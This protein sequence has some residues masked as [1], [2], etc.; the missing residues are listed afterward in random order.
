MSQGVSSGAMAGRTFSSL[1]QGPGHALERSWTSDQ[2]T[3]FR[4]GSN[5]QTPI[6]AKVRGSGAGLRRPSLL[7]PDLRHWYPMW[8]H[9]SDR[10][11]VAISEMGTQQ[12]VAGLCS[13]E[14]AHS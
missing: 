3:G 6:L 12:G 2:P 13:I 7:L 5:S 4:A 1:S 9:A 14:D 10:A 8:L 11:C